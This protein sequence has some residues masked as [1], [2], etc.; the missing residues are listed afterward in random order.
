[1]KLVAIGKR[2]T[3]IPHVVLILWL[4][5]SNY[6]SAHFL[7]KVPLIQVCIAWDLLLPQLASWLELILLYCVM[8]SIEVS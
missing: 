6:K 2:G 4:S 3:L 5:G 7:L 8:K 1:M